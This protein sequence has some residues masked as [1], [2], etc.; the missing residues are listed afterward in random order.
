MWKECAD[1]IARALAHPGADTTS[2]PYVRRSSSRQRRHRLGD[3]DRAQEQYLLALD[4]LE[5]AGT[6]IQIGTVH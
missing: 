6:D 1:E 4:V 2:A 3:L 5:K